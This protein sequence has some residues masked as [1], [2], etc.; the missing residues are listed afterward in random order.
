ME[1]KTVLFAV[2]IILILIL[3]YKN[4]NKKSGFVCS[5]DNKLIERRQITK[6]SKFGGTACPTAGYDEQ[7]IV[8]CDNEI[9]QKDVYQSNVFNID[10]NGKFLRCMRPAT[11]N[12]T[13]DFN[14]CSSE[15]TYLALYPIT[16]TTY[17]KI[18]PSNNRFLCLTYISSTPS[19]PVFKVC[20]EPAFLSAQQF[21]E[22]STTTGRKLIKNVLSGLYFN[23]LGRLVA[24]TT[25]NEGQLSWNT[26]TIN[27]NIVNDPS[28]LIKYNIR[29]YSQTPSQTIGSTTIPANYSCIESD[30]LGYVYDVSNPCTTDLSTNELALY[31]IPD[32]SNYKIKPYSD[33]SLCLTS[34]YGDGNLTFEKCNMFP[35]ETQSFELSPGYG[36]NIK[37]K[38][39]C[40][41]KTGSLVSCDSA[42]S[43]L[44]D[45]YED[46]IFTGT[47]SES[48]SVIFVS[49]IPIITYGT[50]PE[51]YLPA[52]LFNGE[53]KAPIIGKLTVPDP[54]DPNK[55]L[56]NNNIFM[57]F[58]NNRIKPAAN[59]TLCL[60][61]S[62]GYQVTFEKCNMYSNELQLFDVEQSENNVYIKFRGANLYL[63]R[64]DSNVFSL[65]PDKTSKD[66][67]IQTT[68]DRVC[69]DT[70]VAVDPIKYEDGE[71]PLGYTISVCPNYKPDYFRCEM[72][73]S[74]GIKKVGW[75][76]PTCYNYTNDYQCLWG[77][78]YIPGCADYKTPPV[79]ASNPDILKK[80]VDSTTR[81]INIQYARE[82][83]SL[84]EDSGTLIRNTGGIGT[85]DLCWE[86]PQGKADIKFAKLYKQVSGGTDVLLGDITT[87]FRQFINSDNPNGPYKYI[88][89]RLLNRDLTTVPGTKWTERYPELF[90]D[91]LS[92]SN[93]DPAAAYTIQYAWDCIKRKDSS[94]NMLDH[95]AGFD[96]VPQS[97][98][99]RFIIYENGIND[100]Y[101]SIL[102]IT[103][104][105][106]GKFYD[107][108]IL[109][110]CASDS[111]G[112]TSGITGKIKATLYD[113]YSINNGVFSGRQL[114]NVT[115]FISDKMNGRYIDPT[116]TNPT[117]NRYLLLTKNST[118]SV[119]WSSKYG[120]SV[121]D[122]TPKAIVIDVECL[123]T[124]CG[125]YDLQKTADGSEQCDNGLLVYKKSKSL[126]SSCA[127]VNEPGINQYYYGPTT[128]IGNCTYSDA[129]E[130]LLDSSGNKICNKQTGKIK[131]IK[132][133]T[134]QSTNGMLCSDREYD[135]TETCRVDCEVSTPA[136]KCNGNTKKYE[137]KNEIIYTPKNGGTSCPTLTYQATNYT[138]DNIDDCVL[139]ETWGV[140]A[141]CDDSNPLTSSGMFYE[142]PSIVTEAK[143]GGLCTVPKRLSTTRCADSIDCVGTWVPRGRSYVGIIEYKYQTSS[144]EKI[145]YISSNGNV[146]NVLLTNIMTQWYFY[147][148]PDNTYYILLNSNRNLGLFISSGQNLQLRDIRTNDISAW[149]IND[150]GYFGVYS[151]KIVSGVLYKQYLMPYVDTGAI[152]NDIPNI[153]IGSNIDFMNLLSNGF[154]IKL[155]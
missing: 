85:G 132:R 11:L 41:N 56:F 129:D 108:S 75:A 148:N 32:S 113:N 101:S 68:R 88:A 20:N 35:T 42:V 36:I 139:S 87:K 45:V 131:K 64:N 2:L 77:G 9:T 118:P 92:N 69:L 12:S 134:K 53:S 96:S 95:N 70:K 13:I 38:G 30:G 21:A 62:G 31:K 111:Q 60:T 93:Y 135:S 1:I 138:C 44:W 86:F 99:K 121:G 124:T 116:L 155:I 50:P 105:N 89:N 145:R 52:I 79:D 152:M 29:N 67:W 136:Y 51:S 63:V 109:R 80:Y 120:L 48:E 71:I 47:D 34:L 112:N 54:T 49:P 74:G 27:T 81:Q 19:I 110:N 14:N 103:N 146:G 150:S 90:S 102:F 104:S 8:P 107:I 154:T 25:T 114:D 37:N 59:E 33:Q 78:Y 6:Q 43:K 28:Q 122:G 117:E 5:S 57:K 73:E 7:A 24:K 84:Y 147:K 153:A 130:Y 94:G 26:A 143:S 66:L 100:S 39:K 128:C 15:S 149:T 97:K 98:I 16:G 91:F 151:E 82:A 76:T 144:L 46:K 22:E 106:F 40:I 133:V 83:T 115:D 123:N 58:V 142:S 140:T 119:S 55:N 23:H 125:V 10:T 3:F 126:E 61:Y 18:K 141:E 4:T 17:F 127:N 65:S 137:L 72:L